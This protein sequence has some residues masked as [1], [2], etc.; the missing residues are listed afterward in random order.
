[1]SQPFIMARQRAAWTSQRLLTRPQAAR[2]LLSPIAPIWRNYISFLSSKHTTSTGSGDILTRLFPNASALRLRLTPPPRR[3]LH[4][5]FKLRQEPAR[6]SPDPTANLGSPTPTPSLSLSQRLKKLSREYGWSAFGVYMALS[7]LDFPFC[8]LAVRVLGTERIG[9]WEHFVV[10]GA[11]NS[12]YYPLK[13]ALGWEDG[14]AAEAAGHAVEQGWEAAKSG[15]AV[16][17]R[18]PA[19]EEA[20]TNLGWGVEEAQEAAYK[21]DATLWTQLVLAYAIHKSFIFIRVP[22]TA[23]VTP[24]VVKTLRG[25]G[26]D[27][28]KRKP[29]VP[30][31]A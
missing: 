26:W 11:K 16:G 17:V 22:L 21:V 9:R 8:F 25:W 12:I 30:K 14:N 31:S 24:K 20:K 1:M 15:E 13:R 18:E 6:P 4:Q 28:G 3:S 29:K 19:Q 23:A 5:S 7:A 2:Q 10:E 27:I